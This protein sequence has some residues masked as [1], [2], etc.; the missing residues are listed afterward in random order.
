VVGVL[1]QLSQ[2]HNESIAQSMT[3]LCEMLPV[4]AYRVAC[5]EIAVI[6]API[7]IEV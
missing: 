6:F 3:R 7:V 1:E 4:E 5:D 2:V